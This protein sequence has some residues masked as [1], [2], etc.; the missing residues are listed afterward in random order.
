MGIGILLGTHMPRI[1]S[2]YGAIS[3]LEYH[4]GKI[5]SLG[6]KRIIERKAADAHHHSRYLPCIHS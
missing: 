3:I 5:K 6:V 2:V 4:C 1:H